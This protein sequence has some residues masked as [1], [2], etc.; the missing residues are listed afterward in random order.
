MAK[1]FR[2]RSIRA[3]DDQVTNASDLTLKQSLLP[4]ALVTI[5]FFLWVF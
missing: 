5:L 1:F 2:K 4:L 3:R